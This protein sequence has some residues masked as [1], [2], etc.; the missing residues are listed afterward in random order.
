MLSAYYE[1]NY[2]KILDI[3]NGL[4]FDLLN[5]QLENIHDLR[6]IKKEEIDFYV[7][8]CLINNVCL[9]FIP[10]KDKVVYLLGEDYI[11]SINYIQ[12]YNEAYKLYDFGSAI[13]EESRVKILEVI[14]ERGEITCK[15]LER[16]FSFSGSTAYHHL[17]IM[18]K[19]GVIKSRN[20]GK[21]ILYSINNKCFDLMIGVLKKY[22]SNM[23]K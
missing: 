12:E 3:Y 19:S 18:I 7:S 2:T 20:Q 13:S 5:N 16:L 23:E 21:T 4:T 11:S 14:F 1:K 22:S 17:T 8:F 15:D 10:L 9:N 6:F